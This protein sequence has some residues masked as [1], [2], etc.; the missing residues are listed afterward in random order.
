MRLFDH[1][2]FLNG[3]INYMQQEFEGK[4]K[5]IEI[6]HL[7]ST[8]Q[9]STEIVE[10][11]IPRAKIC[12]ESYLPSIKSSVDKALEVSESVFSE[13]FEKSVKEALLEKRAKR[14]AGWESFLEDV[15]QRYQSIDLTFEEKEQELNEFYSDLN[16]KLHLHT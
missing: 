11:H 3:E 7:F 15:N 1:R 6:E 14:E 5:D 8:L 13:D 16:R 12:S 9:V 4:R 10:T 2:P